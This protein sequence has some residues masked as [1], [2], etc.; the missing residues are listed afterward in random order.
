MMTLCVYNTTLISEINTISKTDINPRCR[1]VQ[2]KCNDNI[3]ELGTVHLTAGDD[4]KDFKERA[5]E[6]KTMFEN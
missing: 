5:S 3:I 2:I 4:E 1:F 6:L